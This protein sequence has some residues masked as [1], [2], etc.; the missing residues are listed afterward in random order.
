[1]PI[2]RG[3]LSKSDFGRDFQSADHTA[4]F[5]PPEPETSFET[6]HPILPARLSSNISFYSLLQGVELRLSFPSLDNDTLV[7]QQLPS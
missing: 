1:M 2:P 3:C 4:F 6:P 7:D 5:G